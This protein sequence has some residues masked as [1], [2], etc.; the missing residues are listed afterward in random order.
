MDLYLSQQTLKAAVDRLSIA[1]M[2]TSLADYLIFKRALQNVRTAAR[3]YGNEE[4]TEVV[5]GI[6]SEPYVQAIEEMTLR[7]PRDAKNQKDVENPYY[8]PFGSRRDTTLG[9][10]TKKYPS[11]GS[12]DTATRWQSRAGKPLAQVPGSSPKAF[13]FESRTQAEL[14]SFFS[15]QNAADNFSGEKPRLLDTAIWWFRFTEL[16]ARFGKEPA[17][18][19]LIDAMI[20]DLGLNEVERQ[21]LFSDRVDDDLSGEISE[22]AGEEVL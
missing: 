13:Q 8:L 21:A 1:S 19:E 22:E 7:L 14:E 10:R 11:N 16:N 20:S 17:A 15:I 3:T 9:Y 6:R 2:Q 5:T 12:S 18:Q 4:P